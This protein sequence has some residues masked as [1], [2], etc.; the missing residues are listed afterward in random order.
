MPTLPL[1]PE[2]RLLQIVTALDRVPPARLAAAPPGAS[3]ARRGGRRVRIAVA[4]TAGLLALG[5]VATAS[6][7]FEHQ[8]RQ[9][10]DPK[11][12]TLPPGHSA[13]VDPSQ[14]LM[15]V[16]ATT[17]DGGIAELWE[18]PMREGS[19]HGRCWAILLTDPGRT[20]PDKPYRPG[21]GCGNTDPTAP[22]SSATGQLW[23][24]RRTGRAYTVEG[25]I[26]GAATRVEYRFPDGSVIAAT[27]QRG[28]YLVFVPYAKMQGD[29]RI[30][31]LDSAGRTIA[32]QSRPSPDTAPG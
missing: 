16:R 29:H 30:V 7:V 19:A 14:A 32:S 4:A 28:R 31:A 20:P 27:V 1:M 15:S 2:D 21:A 5:G 24:S 13:T 26:A 10:F 22:L 12:I 9:A 11:R 8:A 25:G 18:T 3:R 6:G 23:V 17:P